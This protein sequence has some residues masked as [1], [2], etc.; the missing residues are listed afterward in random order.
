MSVWDA[1]CRRPG[2]VLHGDN[3]DIACDHY[4]R[5][6]EDVALMKEIGLKA[7]RFSIS[8]PRV[9]HRMVLKLRPRSAKA[10]RIPR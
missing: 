8:W 4:H 1:F 7:Y 6:R 10:I 5:Y 3:G 2:A 9:E